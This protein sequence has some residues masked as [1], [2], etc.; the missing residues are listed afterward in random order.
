[1]GKAGKCLDID[2]AI[3]QSRMIRPRKADKALLEQTRP[4]HVPG[5]IREHPDG[6]VH[7]ATVEHHADGIL[8]VARDPQID[9]RRFETYRRQQ[10]W[11]KHER[12]EIGAGEREGL[13]R[14]FR[15]KSDMPVHD[16]S[17]PGQERVDLERQLPGFRCR[18]HR[19]GGADEELIP[20]QQA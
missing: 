4:D 10:R 14:L 13:R 8:L 7:L 16:G 18:L 20:E 15:K 5:R 11:Q 3:R 6:E 19:A 9:I 1:M 2:P 17:H 12:R